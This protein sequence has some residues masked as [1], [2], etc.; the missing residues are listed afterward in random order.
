MREIAI[1][2]IEARLEKGGADAKEE[3]RKILNEIRNMKSNDDF[4]REL[5]TK[6][7]RFITAEPAQQARINQMFDETM[8][9]LSEYMNFQRVQDLET[10]INNMK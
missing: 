9:L 2:R 10:R 3:A 7:A 1:A 8:K 4:I 5:Q 6:K